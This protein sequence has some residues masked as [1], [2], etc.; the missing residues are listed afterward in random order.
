MEKKDILS[1]SYIELKKLLDNYTIHDAA[2]RASTFQILFKKRKEE[3]INLS[4]EEINELNS[5]DRICRI[6][7]N[8][9]EKNRINYL[10]N[11]LSQGPFTQESIEYYKNRVKSC[12]SAE[13]NAKYCEV[14]WELNKRNKDFAILAI[15]YLLEIANSN[16]H[17][18]KYFWRALF[19]VTK[20][21]S[22]ELSKTVT[23]KMLKYVDVLKVKKRYN[24]INQIVKTFTKNK[25]IYNKIDF[26]NLEN[27]LEEGIL[28]NEKKDVIRC[29]EFI[30][31]INS[32]PHIK[33]DISRVKNNKARKASFIEQEAEEGIKNRGFILNGYTKAMYILIDAMKL[34]MESGN[35]P[36]K[37]NELKNKIRE[38]TIIAINNEW[39]ERQYTIEMPSK[40]FNR[41]LLSFKDK[42]LENILKVIC[43]TKCYIPSFYEIQTNIESQITN[44]PIFNIDYFID[45]LKVS[46]AKTKEEC[47]VNESINITKKHIISYNLSFVNRLFNNYLDN[48]IEK[49][50]NSFMKYLESSSNISQDRIPII[51]NA[52]ESYVQKNFISGINVL[53]FQLE[54]ILR[55][56]DFQIQGKTFSYRNTKMLEYT[57][58][59]ILTNLKQSSDIN[60]NTIKFLEITLIETRG[61]NYRNKIGHG[62]TKYDEFNINLNQFLIFILIILSNLN[63]NKK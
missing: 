45:D 42:S 24:I 12:Q 52:I 21:K 7:F 9:N 16:I 13:W 46:Q 59:G 44:H 28:Y 49:D 58:G 19:I 62:L 40:G 39:I 25:Y 41:L 22:E 11:P 31:T 61:L 55:E 56:L 32:L 1:L 36:E 17:P 35:S 29:Q 10:G 34:Y 27:Y 47:I 6:N 14:V 33:T 8:S 2:E 15:K 51:Q 53:I 63:L 43:D 4:K 50:T 48:F 26:Y 20:I 54:G 38:Y 3:N 60:I 23:S 57:F 5:E 18:F 37:V 30:D